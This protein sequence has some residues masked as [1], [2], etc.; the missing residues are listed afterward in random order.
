MKRGDIWLINLDP[1]IG[2]EIRKTRPV[3]IVNNDAVG[4]LALKI[5]IP[6]TDWKERYAR[7][8]WMVR[9]DPSQENGLV[10][11]SAADTFQIKSVSQER[12]IKQ[13]GKVSRGDMTRIAEALVIVLQVDT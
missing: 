11:L 7:L 6:T 4:T 5:V 8:P 13:L 2:D 10:K 1:T 12:F 3:I 9:V